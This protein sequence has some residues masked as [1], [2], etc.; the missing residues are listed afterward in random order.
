MSEY[1][2]AFDL[3]S[4]PAQVT[5]DSNIGDIYKPALLLLTEVVSLRFHLDKFD[6][7]FVL[8]PED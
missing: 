5:L 7:L 6:G 3:V 4:D 8:S 2:H 1:I